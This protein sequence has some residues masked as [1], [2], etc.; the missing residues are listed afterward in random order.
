MLFLSVLW[1][2]CYNIFNRTQR[3]ICL[4]AGFFLSMTINAMWF[5]TDTS[6]V[7]T[8]VNIGFVSVHYKQI[9]VG[10]IGTILTFPFIAG[11]NVMFRHR[12]MKVK[13]DDY[14]VA[15]IKQNGCLPHWTGYIG[16]MVC[17]MTI[18]AGCVVTTLYSLQW[19]REK[20]NDWLMSI[21]FGA[22]T[23][24]TIG[25]LQVYND[26]FYTCATMCKVY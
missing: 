17:L 18:I 21:Y 19:G 13:V 5:G 24:L 3:F 7:A 22:L 1:R 8:K 12:K 4:M 23:D 26:R 15:V 2:P 11:L 10:A 9:F 6:G 25:P 20:S 14:R 16:S